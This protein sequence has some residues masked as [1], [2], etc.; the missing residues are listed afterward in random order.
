MTQIVYSEEQQYRMAFYQNMLMYST[1]I[2]YIIERPP[3]PTP[4]IKSLPL[5][6]SEDPIY[7]NFADHATHIYI[8]NCMDNLVLDWGMKPIN[9][10]VGEITDVYVL[11]YHYVE[12]Q[13]VIKRSEYFN[14]LGS[15]VLTTTFKY[16]VTELYNNTID[17]LVFREL[18]HIHKSM[19]KDL[20]EG[21]ELNLK[22]E[23]EPWQP[24]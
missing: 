12:V 7:S 14:T 2:S 10:Q 16:D 24:W 4:E 22:P 18:R 9:F 5:R 23:W 6:I 11:K 8:S 13:F 21:T 3:T 17:T 20:T 1:P 19:M 15:L